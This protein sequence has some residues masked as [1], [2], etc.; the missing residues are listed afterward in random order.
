MLMTDGEYRIEIN[1]INHWVK[2]D[3][4]ENE[5]V[6]LV[7]IH[8]GPGGNLYTFERTVGPL[9]AVKRTIVYYEQRGSGRTEK[10]SSDQDYS[11]KFLIEDFK[12]IKNW[13]G[14]EK[15]D[16]LGFSF[17]GELALEISDALPEVIHSIVL[18]APSLMNSEINKM[19]QITGF[20]SVVNNELYNEI[21]KIQKEALSID[22]IYNKVWSLVDTE[23]VDLLLFENQEN[24]KMNRKLWEESNLVNTGLMYKALQKIPVEKPLVDRL[25]YIQQRTLIITGVFDRN[26][27]IPVSKIFAREIPNNNWVLFNRSAHF[28]DLEETNQFVRTVI[29]FL[30]S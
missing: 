28:P 30:E 11:I 22:E 24:A 19:V 18:S 5:T 13:L 1:G 21:Q 25:K 12:E 2:I 14:A 8:G 15:V 4:S 9:L 6:P 10:P 26:T 29:D 7:I 20:M 17:G 16:L 23:T 27:G 3:G